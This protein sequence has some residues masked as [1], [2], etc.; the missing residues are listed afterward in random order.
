MKAPDLLN[1]AVRN[2]R[3]SVFRNSLTTLGITV[4]IASLVAM[5]ALGVGL[6]QMADQRLAR[7]VGCSFSMVAHGSFRQIR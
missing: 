7:I 5:S 3:E 4:G 6:Q 1:L 2:L